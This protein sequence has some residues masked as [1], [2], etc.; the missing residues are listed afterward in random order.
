VRSCRCPG[1]GATARHRAARLG[2]RG[3]PSTRKARAEGTSD[4]P[5][6]LGSVL[7]WMERIRIPW[8]RGGRYSLRSAPRPTWSLPLVSGAPVPW[9]GALGWCRQGAGFK[10]CDVP[11]RVR[12][13]PKPSRAGAV[14]AELRL[15]ERAGD[16]ACFL[17]RR[18]HG[19][20][21]IGRTRTCLVIGQRA[22]PARLAPGAGSGGVRVNR[23]ACLASG[24]SVTLVQSRAHG[25]ASRLSGDGSTSTSGSC[26]ALACLSVFPLPALAALGWIGLLLSGAGSPSRVV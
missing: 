22:R 1:E 26:P 7:K 9:A 14:V 3:A 24:F 20:S 16:G 25:D 21:S 8:G 23:K 15:A 18:V 11:D 5:T 6:P 10:C 19:P 17:S 4:P 12:G 2:G 13:E